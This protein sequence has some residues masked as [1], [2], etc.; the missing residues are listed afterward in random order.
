MRLNLTQGT[1]AFVSWT[2][3]GAFLH[4][5]AHFCAFG[6]SLTHVGAC[7]R[8][9]THVDANWHTLAAR[10][11]ALSTCVREIQQIRTHEARTFHTSSRNTTSSQPGGAYFTHMFAP[12]L[13]FQHR[14]SKL[15]FSLGTCAKNST[16][17]SE[18]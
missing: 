3:I 2:H 16:Q 8:T 10:K 6:R 11:R 9:L 18:I 15:S 13:F 4:T 17:M 12:Q 5:L 14:L 7:R 1:F